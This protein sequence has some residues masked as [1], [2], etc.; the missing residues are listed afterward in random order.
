MYSIGNYK[1]LILE[2]ETSRQRLE[3]IEGQKEQLTKL[4]YAFTSPVK[5]LKAMVYDDM[6]KGGQATE[7]ERLEEGMRKLE[8][9]IDIEER[10]LLKAEETEA[11]INDR[12]KKFEGIDYK[13]A[14]LM[15][16]KGYTVQEVADELGYSFYYIQN[17]SAKVNKEVL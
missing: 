5:E 9:M 13:V 16:I 11:K 6:P 8:N 2:I 14:Y 7:Y 12:L 1:E 10:I 15:Q 4:M 3:C 17:I